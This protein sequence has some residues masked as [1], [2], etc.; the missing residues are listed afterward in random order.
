MRDRSQDDLNVVPKEWLARKIFH[1]KTFSQ[2]VSAVE[3]LFFIKDELLQTQVRTQQKKTFPFSFRC[4][5]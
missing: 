1:K 5:L 3:R 2:P 4:D